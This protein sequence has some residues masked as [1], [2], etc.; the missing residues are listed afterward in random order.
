MAQRA[1][2][3]TELILKRDRVGMRWLTAG[4]VIFA[5]IIQVNCKTFA[6]LF[7]E[8]HGNPVSGPAPVF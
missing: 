6:Q 8:P 3:H 2:P 5:L 4:I 1:S 7:M